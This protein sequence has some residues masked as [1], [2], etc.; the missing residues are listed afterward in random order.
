MGTYKVEIEGRYNLDEITLQI[1]GEE[2]GSSEFQESTISAKKAPATNVV[3]FRTLSA[4]T[5][6]KTLSV[7]RQGTVQPAG[8]TRIWAGTMIVGGVNTA[9]VAY[10]KS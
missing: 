7:V 4:G 1:S 3:V 10:R 8:T 6:P 2:A 9:V 5:V